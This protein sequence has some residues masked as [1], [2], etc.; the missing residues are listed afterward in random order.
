[1]PYATIRDSRLF[2]EDTRDGKILCRAA[3]PNCLPFPL[4]GDTSLLAGIPRD[5]MEQIPGMPEPDTPYR[6]K[7]RMTWAA[8]IK[9]VL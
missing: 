2:Y 1:M 5:F 8:L 9:C 7:C 4:S 3:H 6:R